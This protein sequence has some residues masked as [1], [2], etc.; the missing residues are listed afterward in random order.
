MNFDFLKDL[1][2]LNPI[3]TSYVSNNLRSIFNFIVDDHVKEKEL[4]SNNHTLLEKLHKIFSLFLNNNLDTELLYNL[5]GRNLDL[6]NKQFYY[7]YDKIKK[8]V[9]TIN[10]IESV[11]SIIE[12]INNTENIKGVLI[13]T[14][15]DQ[16]GFANTST[17]LIRECNNAAK[18]K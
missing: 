8:D 5:F 1:V 12:N 11:C 10:L 16:N 2:S 17:F 7:L 15:D 18:I 14:I 4:N 3:K 6:T 9:F 13:N